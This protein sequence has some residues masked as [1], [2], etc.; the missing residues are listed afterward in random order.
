MSRS[1][2]SALFAFFSSR[3]RDVRRRG[4][5]HLLLGVVLAMLCSCATV[6]GAVLRDED[7]GQLVLATPHTGP[8]CP[9]QRVAVALTADVAG[10]PMRSQGVGGG[11][12]SWDSFFIDGDGAHLEQ[13][14]DQLWARVE[15]DGRRVPSSVRLSARLRHQPDVVAEDLVLPVHF[16]CPYV[17]ARRGRPGDDGDDGLP[18]RD[19]NG[20]SPPSS[21]APG[22]R[23]QAGAP[24][25]RLQ[26]HVTPAKGG[27]WWVCVRD[28]PRSTPRN[29][30]PPSSDVAERDDVC[31]RLGAGGFVN[32][33]VSGGDG[34]RG[35]QGGPGG[36][37]G[38]GRGGRLLTGSAGYGRDGDGGRGGN[39][40]D[41]VVVVDD[42]LSLADVQGRVRVQINGGRGGTGGVLAGRAPDGRKG[43][44]RWQWGPTPTP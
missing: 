16:S 30:T 5:L 18:G 24:G 23:G 4:G 2:R 44:V 12:L 8:V 38:V 42:R 34:G 33:D 35:G 41:V 10:R 3:L 15:L 36:N 37:A 6:G 28:A 14:G 17:L 7:V 9:G 29:A 22:R 32:V 13:Q 21:G 39:G 26:V 20:F 11:Q 31:L 43:R 40:G 19:G 27:D 25:A 1:P